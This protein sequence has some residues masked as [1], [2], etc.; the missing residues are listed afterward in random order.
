VVKNK[1]APPFREALLD[2][3]FGW[4]IDRYAD[5]VTMAVEYNIIQKAGSW[6]ALDDERIGQGEDAVKDFLRGNHEAENRLR[7]LILARM[8]P[9]EPTKA[10]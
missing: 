6:Y 3:I 10:P 9:V 8:D 7:A 1:V 5:L 4:G 2:I